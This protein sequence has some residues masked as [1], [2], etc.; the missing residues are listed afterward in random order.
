MSMIREA[1]QRTIRNNITLIYSCR[2]QEDVPFAD[3]LIQLE[4][5]NTNLSVIF[6][7]TKGETDRFMGKKVIRGVITPDVLDR[8]MRNSYG[9]YT[10]YVCGPKAFMKAI[11]KTLL[12]RDVFSEH[13][14]TEDFGLRSKQLPS[15][16]NSLPGRVYSSTVLSLVLGTAMVMGVD[17][18]GTLAKAM[19]GSSNPAVVAPSQP[20]TGS[21]SSNSTSIATPQSNNSVDSSSNQSANNSNAAGGNTGSAAPAQ[22]NQSTS[23]SSSS[24]ANTQSQ[25]YQQPTSSVS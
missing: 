23:N 5:Q 15:L 20:S 12:A 18:R 24:V 9:Y 14:Y 21:S 13:I 25:S 11:E 3:D 19:A 8:I 17:L 2:N 6:A 22:S 7:I 4:Q 1:T 10:Y 16:R